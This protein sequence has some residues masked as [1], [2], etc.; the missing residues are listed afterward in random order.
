MNTV[1]KKLFI[2]ILLIAVS[3]AIHAQSAQLNLS[4]NIRELYDDVQAGAPVPAG[5]FYVLNGT[6][7]ARKITNADEGVFVGELIISSGSWL[8]EGN[9]ELSSCIIV[10]AG[11]SYRKAIP[12][13]R[14]R[15]AN[16]D[17]IQLKSELLV[18]GKLTGTAEYDG[19]MLPVIEAEG[20]RRLD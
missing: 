18:Y 13:R 2:L 4:V 19:E 15:R 14:S 3:A 9:I 1:E 6:V 8:D 16:P 5:G 7:T 10:L 17:E 11:E 12:A 20:L